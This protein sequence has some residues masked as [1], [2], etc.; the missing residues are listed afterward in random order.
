MR[1]IYKWVVEFGCTI[2]VPRDFDDV[3][4]GEYPSDSLIP[5]YYDMTIHHKYYLTKNINA[6]L[7]L[8]EE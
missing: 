5:I 6:S 8:K 2:K 4:D 3:E 7:N 1:L